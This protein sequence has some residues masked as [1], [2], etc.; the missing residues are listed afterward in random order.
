MENW[1][2]KRIEFVTKF[3]NNHS[4][5]ILRGNDSWDY[6]SDIDILCPDFN[7]EN[8][9]QRYK[10]DD[11]KIDIFKKY[12]IKKIEI[13][14]EKLLP[15]KNNNN[16]LSSDIESLL[17]F[18]KDYIHFTNYRNKKHKFYKKPKNVIPFLKQI[19]CPL[20]IYIFLRPSSNIISF[21]IR[22]FLVK[23]IYYSS[24]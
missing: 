9:L 20:V 12:R 1:K 11:T 16:E 6:N 17:F 4:Y 5:I 15:F 23:M 2:K 22:S 21:I 14:Y 3:F 24:F 7:Q 10:I 18:L 8:N 13:G 19:N